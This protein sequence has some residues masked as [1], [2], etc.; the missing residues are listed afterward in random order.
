[1]A[2]DIPLDPQFRSLL[3]GD[4]R[5]LYFPNTE[6]DRRAK[7]QLESAFVEDFKCHLES[8]GMSPA[9]AEREIVRTAGR[10]LG[11]K[12]VFGLRKRLQRARSL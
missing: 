1:V 10:S 9:E 4:L 8:A 6:R 3:A 12:T 2:S 5:R 7:A 11:I